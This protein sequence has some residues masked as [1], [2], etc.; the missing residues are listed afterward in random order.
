MRP[1]QRAIGFG[2][3]TPETR[4]L[5][6]RQQA[7][8][9]E[10]AS[11]A[12][13]SAPSWPGSAHRRTGRRSP[14]ARCRTPSRAMRWPARR[15]RRGST[16]S[17]WT[18]TIETSYG[19]SRNACLNSCSISRGRLCDRQVAAV[20][21][22][23]RDIRSAASSTVW[24]KSVSL[25]FHAF[26]R[27]TL[28]ASPSTSSDRDGGRERPLLGAAR[29][30]ADL[31]RDRARD[32]HDSHAGEEQRPLRRDESRRHDQVAHGQ[33]G[34]DEPEQS[35]AGHRARDRAARRRAARRRCR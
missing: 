27:S 8:R 13:S 4:Q 29:A 21:E 16:S 25:S 12:S 32:E 33:E 26:W 5:A 9:L 23:A 24:A 31:L 35:E 20:A 2:E 34:D 18:S 10:G 17:R 19:K 3:C 30:R 11:R 1:P 22:S 15:A 7:H 14:P 28:R 6:A